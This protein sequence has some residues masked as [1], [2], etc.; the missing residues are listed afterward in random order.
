MNLRKAVIFA[1][2][3]AALVPGLQ[4]CVRNPATGGSTFTG[5]MTTAKEISIGRESHPKIVKEFGGEYGPPEL[6]AYVSSVGQLLARTVERKD[7]PYK[8]TLLNSKIVNAFAMPGGY[9]YIT[10][11]LLA[12]ADNEAQL[13]AVLAHELGHITA[14]HHARRYGQGILANVLM[15]GAGI[16]VGSVAGRGLL[17]AGQVGT[18]AILRGFSRENEF[19][20]DELGVRYLSRAGYDPGAMAGF[21]KKLRADSQLSA[22][23]RGD[24]PDKVD[25]FNYL[26]TH[27]API[28]R[29]NRARSMAQGAKVR[30]PMT[31]Q[32]IYFSKIDGILY[33]D[34]PGQGL[35]Q[36]RVFVHPKLRFR[37]EVPKGFRLVNS[38]SAVIGRGPGDSRI[39]FDMAKKPSDGAL[40][41]YLT[42]VWARGRSLSGVAAI[43]INGM[44]AATGT[45]QVRTDK[46]TFDARLLAIRSNLQTIFRFLFV[47]PPNLTKKLAVDLRRTTFSF[48]RISAR[49]ASAVK[50]KK[51]KVF[52]IGAGD[53]QKRLAGFMAFGDKREER[54]RVLNGLAPGQRLKVGQLVKV[55][56]Q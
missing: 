55:I 21:L 4:G 15:T 56:R 6:R 50:P 44:D 11:G 7:F 41:Y 16:M 27:P 38:P 49:E 42:K 3:A 20:S 8:F 35:I 48:R 17:Q 26:A 45:T 10:R 30:S 13:G 24:S 18:M 23:L 1:A 39:I 25:K 40:T 47:T 51:L 2:L 46:G 53:T 37:F 33:G 32:K 43:K 31:A 52:R 34:D 29:V 36:G 5:G 14:L 9:I 28:E 54:F 19:E 12:L 22:R